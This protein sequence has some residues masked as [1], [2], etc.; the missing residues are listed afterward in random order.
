[1]AAPDA[2][3]LALSDMSWSKYSKQ[4]EI[5]KDRIFRLA[6]NE[7][8]SVVEPNDDDILVTAYASDEQCGGQVNYPSGLSWASVGGQDALLL[9]HDDGV[10]AYSLADLEELEALDLNAFGRNFVQISAAPAN[11]SQFYAMPMCKSSQSDFTLPYGSETE[12]ADKNLVAVLDMANGL[13]LAVTSIDID[14]NGS[15]D[16]GIDLDYYKIKAYIRSFDTTM[17]IPPVVFTGPQMAVGTSMLVVR[18]T[19]IQGNGGSAISS[20]GLGQAQ[21]LSIHDLV[22]GQ[23]VVLNDY[24]PFFDGLS[25]EAGTGAAI[26]GLDAWSGRESSVGWVEYLLPAEN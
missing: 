22:T 21:D 9:G 16:H 2:S 17:P 8:G 5:L 15:P 6:L 11:P 3:A 13:D 14:K 26:W 1:V 10:T 4:E 20:S 23:G 19:G 18:G 12:K 7:D 25:S 24:V